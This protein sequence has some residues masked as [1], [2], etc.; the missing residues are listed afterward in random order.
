LE[1]TLL[2]HKIEHLLDDMLPLVEMERVTQKTEIVEF[3]ESD[4]D[5]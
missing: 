2:E 4:E 5:Y 3:S 1:E